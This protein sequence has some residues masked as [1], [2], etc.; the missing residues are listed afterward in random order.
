[1]FD[2][3]VISG[4]C[5]AEI[6]LLQTLSTEDEGKKKQ[7]NRLEVKV[8]KYLQTGGRMVSLYTPHA[9]SEESQVKC[10]CSQFLTIMRPWH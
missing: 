6:P 8:L 3:Q 1:M 10:L 4:M 2:A 9:K 5:S 7:R